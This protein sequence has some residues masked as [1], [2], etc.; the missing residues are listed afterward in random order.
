MN[1]GPATILLNLAVL[2]AF[3]VWVP[4]R[5]GFDFLDPVMI[6]AYAML[7]LL[8]VAPAAAVAC[9]P[10]SARGLTRTAMLGRIVAAVAYG[11]GTA[12]IIL[13]IALIT[14][15]ATAWHGRAVLPPLKI[16]SSAV[17]MSLAGSLFVA[18]LGALVTL[19]FSAG[20]AR[21]FFRF[22]FLFLLLALTFSSRF[23]PAEWKVWLSAQMTTD[24][25]SRLALILTGN[26]AALDAL[27]L[28][29]L[30]SR[31]RESPG[32]FQG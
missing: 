27:L 19:S 12:M 13:V 24:G 29:G 6:L 10:D 14:I 23:L 11:W 9:A 1:N 31:T 25:L 22:A 2:L 30:F 8:F 7:A 20:A 4:W 32:R 26:F 28:L 21:N 5:R 17:L 3:G 18:I 15:N 16:L